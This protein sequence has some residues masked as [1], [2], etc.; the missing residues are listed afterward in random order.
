M[1]AGGSVLT[2][3]PALELKRWCRSI[4]ALAPMT[5]CKVSVTYTLELSHIQRV[6][7]NQDNIDFFMLYGKK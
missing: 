1:A 4:A 2:V 5:I 7:K 6:K 3:A